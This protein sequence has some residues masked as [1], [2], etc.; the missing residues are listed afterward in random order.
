MLAQRQRL[1]ANINPA[2]G[3]YFV[4][5]V[6]PLSFRIS[7]SENTRRFTNAVL[8]LGRRLRRRLNIKPAMTQRLTVAGIESPRL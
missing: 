8:M 3:E 6:W 4:L 2:L 5:A 7:Q 1:W